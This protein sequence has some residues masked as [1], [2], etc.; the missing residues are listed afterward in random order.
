[1]ADH[2]KTW[3]LKV[4]PLKTDMFEV[5]VNSTA[6]VTQLKHEIQE[7]TGLE[8]PLQRLIFRGKILKDNQTI[9]RCGISNGRTLLCFPLHADGVA[10]PYAQRP[11]YNVVVSEQL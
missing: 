2:G 9:S 5:E 3:T 4:Q 11:E 1:M 6:S 8:P 10:I 7:F